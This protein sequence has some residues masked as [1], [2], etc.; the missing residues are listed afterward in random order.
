MIIAP[1]LIFIKIT[2]ESKNIKTFRKSIL[3]NI[4][5]VNAIAMYKKKY[6]L[7]MDGSSALSFKLN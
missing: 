6:K 7:I 5:K 3:K 2:I 4:K 1:L